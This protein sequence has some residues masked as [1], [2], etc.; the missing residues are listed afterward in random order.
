LKPRAPKRKARPQEGIKED[1]SVPVWVDPHLTP[2][3]YKRLN[4][5]ASTCQ[6]P[7][8]QVIQ[9]GIELFLQRHREEQ[10]A[11]TKLSKNKANAQAVREVLGNISR[12]YWEGV[13]EEEKRERG[14]KAAQARWAKKKT[15]SPS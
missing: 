15:E 9:E 11:V 10:S 3:F 4:A 8:Y 1:L 7:R 5:I 6:A 2:A 13:S 12:T 14:R